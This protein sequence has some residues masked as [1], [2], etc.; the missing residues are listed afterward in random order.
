MYCLV[1]EIVDCMLDKGFDEINKS[2]IEQLIQE[3]IPE[4]RTLDYKKQ[5]PGDSDDDKKNF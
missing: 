3:Q 2:D 1:S 5:L 4:S